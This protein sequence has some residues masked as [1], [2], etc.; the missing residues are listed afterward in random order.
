MWII[1]DG[2]HEMLQRNYQADRS[3]INYFLRTMEVNVKVTES[4]RT[5][6]LNTVMEE[7]YLKDSLK[8][9]PLRH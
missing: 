5:G 7:R 1:K 2:M 4:R 6:L 3:V 9:K 8:L